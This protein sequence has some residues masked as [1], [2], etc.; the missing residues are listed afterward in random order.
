MFFVIVVKKLCFVFSVCIMLCCWVRYCLERD[1]KH[2]FFDRDTTMLGKLLSLTERMS[3]YSAN[4][5]F[6]ANK[7]KLAILKV[8]KV[9]INTK[10][11]LN[12]FLQGDN[13]ILKENFQ[14]KEINPNSN[15]PSIFVAPVADVAAQITFE[16]ARIIRKIHPSEFMNL[17]WQ[18]K[19][20]SSLA[21][22]LCEIVSRFNNFSFSI[23]H[24]ICTCKDLQKRISMVEYFI[25]LA[26]VSEIVLKFSFY[27]IFLM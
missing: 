16:H 17:N 2:K 10:L 11:V 23:S 15:F 13:T 8:C 4:M 25:N 24:M 5:K 12:F 18:R 27:L 19:N 14:I 20:A 21:P 22:N 6:Q 9:K 26:H 3:K 7:V 1:F